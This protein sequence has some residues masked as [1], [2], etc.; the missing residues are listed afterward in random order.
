[1]EQDEE[2]DAA[3]QS[4]GDDVAGGDHRLGRKVQE[5]PEN[6]NEKQLQSKFWLI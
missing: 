5:T 6:K 1:M 3:D 2:G 4:L